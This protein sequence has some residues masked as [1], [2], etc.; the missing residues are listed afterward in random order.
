LVPVE[1]ITMT[2]GMAVAFPRTRR[3]RPQW[4]STQLLAD[5]FG[6]DQGSTVST[7]AAA[8]LIGT[9]VAVLAGSLG[10]APIQSKSF[11][12]STGYAPTTH[13]SMDVVDIRS[14]RPPV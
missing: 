8:F 2:D 13:T 11:V 6:A 4:A 14:G 1:N 5:V 7:S 9:D 3:E 12:R 10:K